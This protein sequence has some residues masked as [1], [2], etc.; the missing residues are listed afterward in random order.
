MPHDSLY[1]SHSLQTQ[2]ERR[3]KFQWLELSL[4][5]WAIQLNNVSSPSLSVFTGHRLRPA[6]L[7]SGFHLLSALLVNET[8]DYAE[9][10]KSTFE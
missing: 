1:V 3:K 2:K 8:M 6:V 9:R 4:L 7:E 10:R 5:L